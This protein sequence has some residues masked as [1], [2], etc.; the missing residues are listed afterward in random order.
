MLGQCYARRLPQ[1]PDVTALIDLKFFR[2]TL[3]PMVRYTA[4]TALT[5]EQLKDIASAIRH[6]AEQ[7]EGAAKSLESNGIQE[8]E[9]RNYDSLKDGV[10]RINRHISAVNEAVNEAVLSLA[11]LTKDAEAAK[12]QL[13][14]QQRFVSTDTSEESVR[15]KRKG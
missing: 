11:K 8:I 2:G 5:A 9:A 7:Y 12:T 13:K 1:L 14:A 4:K 10:D 6:F 3:W 15:K